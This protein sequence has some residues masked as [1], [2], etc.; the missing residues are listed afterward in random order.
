MEIVTTFKAASLAA[1][2]QRHQLQLQQHVIDISKE[3]LA[4]LLRG[5][6]LQG[7]QVRY[8]IARSYST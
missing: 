6:S 3:D 7:N 4:N 1:R 8:T 2:A 5:A